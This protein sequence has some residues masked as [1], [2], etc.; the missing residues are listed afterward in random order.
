MKKS[1]SVI[2]ILLFIL[3]NQISAQQ[4]D[5]WITY[6]TADGLADNYVYAIV[7]ASDGALWIVIYNGGVS[8]YDQGSWTTLTTADWLVDNKF[9]T[10]YLIVEDKRGL[11]TVAKRTYYI[12]NLMI[13]Q[14]DGF[15]KEY[16]EFRLYIQPNGYETSVIC[17]EKMNIDDFFFGPEMLNPTDL[18]VQL[19]SSIDEKTATKTC[20]VLNE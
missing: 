19:H 1:S 9:Y 10:L 17:L 16:A 7:E 18:I 13:D 2:L 15:K 6:T 4:E 8:R 20:M 14:R 5:L 3:S 12:D 11:K